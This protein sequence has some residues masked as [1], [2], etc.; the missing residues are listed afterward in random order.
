M[1]GM[2]PKT[3]SIDSEKRSDDSELRSLLTRQ[4]LFGNPGRT[5]VLVLIAG[6]GRSYPRELSRLT[7]LPMSSIGRALEDFE[8]S[9]VI[10]ST[11]LAGAREVRLN[12]DYV[13]AREL[14][15]LLEALVEREARYRAI[16]SEA[17]RRR[18]RRAGKET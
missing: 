18:P 9:G 6:L 3:L 14:R 13:A 5:D 15:A 1:T 7:G 8:R 16:L 2:V 17:A 12:P 11:R 4:A 10:V